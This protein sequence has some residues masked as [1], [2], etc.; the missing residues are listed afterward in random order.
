M[1][2]AIT[3]QGRLAGLISTA[4][5]R[6]KMKKKAKKRTKSQQDAFDRHVEAFKDFGYEEEV[7]TLAAKMLFNL[8]RADREQPRHLVIVM[9]CAETVIKDQRSKK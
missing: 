4:Q 2:N 3:T 5:K 7:A 1:G 9:A 8:S 6:E